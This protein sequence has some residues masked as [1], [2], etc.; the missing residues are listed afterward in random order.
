[1]ETE[2]TP[3]PLTTDQEKILLELEMILS[4]VK[5][6]DNNL[7]KSINLLNNDAFDANAPGGPKKTTEEGQHYN[8]LVKSNVQKITEI[9]HLLDTI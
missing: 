1:M 5:Q 2:M 4:T 7:K 9:L 6:I 8:E 3:P